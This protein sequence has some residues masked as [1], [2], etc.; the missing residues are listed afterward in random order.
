MYEGH[1]YTI[2]TSPE[3]FMNEILLIDWLKA[4]FPPWSQNLRLKF[5][6]GGPILL[7]LDGHMSHVTSRVLE[8]AG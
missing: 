3:T 8:Y 7:F 6:D 5:Q 1:D 2:R 4:V